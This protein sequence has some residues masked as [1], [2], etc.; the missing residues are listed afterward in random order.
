MAHI[1]FIDPIE[2]LTVKKDSSLI[3]ALA[4]QEAG[5]EV[6][7]LLGKDFYYSNGQKDHR[8][9]LSKFAGDWDKDGFFL[10]FFSLQKEERRPFFSADTLHMRPEPPFD[11]RYLSY[12]WMLQGIQKQTGIEIINSTEGLLLHNEKVCAYQLDCSVESFVG[13]APDEFAAFAEQL[14][15]SGVEEIVLKPLDLYQGEGVEKIPL[16]NHSDLMKR[17]EQKI[18]ISRG[19][20]VAQP[21]L[22]Q[23]YDGEVRSVFFDGEELGNILKIPKEGDFLSTVSRGARYHSTTL[24]QPQ[25]E[26]CERAARELLKSGIRWIA[27]D[28]LGD[29]IQEVNITCPGLLP[30]ISLANGKR[31]VEHMVCGLVK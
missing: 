22:P 9:R 25:R 12:L 8:Y 16:K 7:L 18:L 6:L 17:F 27:F 14:A 26:N 24:T 30:E 3:L 21:F 20:V 1:F 29:S 10:E 15:Q 4:L 5:E 11:K 23:I 28:I 31:L 13:S 2:K 19:P